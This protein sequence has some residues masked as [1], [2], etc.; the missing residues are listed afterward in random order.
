MWIF[1]GYGV[2]FIKDSGERGGCREGVN[3]GD[4]GGSVGWG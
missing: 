3:G 1:K 4:G 2:V